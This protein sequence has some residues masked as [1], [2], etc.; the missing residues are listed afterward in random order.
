MAAPA[1]RLARA[2]N[3][4]PARMKVVTTEAVSR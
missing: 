1:L 3:Q 4:R 2:S